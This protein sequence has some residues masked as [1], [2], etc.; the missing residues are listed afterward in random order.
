[1]KGGKNI[2]RSTGGIIAFFL[3]IGMSACAGNPQAIVDGK[4]GA[5]VTSGGKGTNDAAHRIR[6]NPVLDSTKPFREAL[7]LAFAESAVRLEGKESKIEGFLQNGE[8]RIAATAW[9]SPSP[10]GTIFVIHGF[11]STTRSFTIAIQRLSELGFD[12]VSIDLP[13][14]GKSDG[15]NDDIRNF[16]VYGDAVTAVLGSCEEIL[17]RP[18]LALG[19]SL[20]ALAV[21]DS[22]SRGSAVVLDAMMFITPLTRSIHWTSSYLGYRLARPF[23]SYT[24]DSN[25]K[26]F[27]LSWFGAMVEWNREAEG[28]PRIDVPAMVILGGADRVVDGPN[29]ERLFGDKISNVQFLRFRWLDHVEIMSSSPDPRLWNAIADFIK[30]FVIAK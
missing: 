26:R 11:G 9:L 29:A 5:M 24:R 15:S 21:Y 3:C 8:Y 10:L 12:V 19:H 14:H 17:P 13:G 30:P 7:Q 22:Q 20:G 23:I 16:R 25:G 4:H 28:F 2:S 1:M 27:P 18:F 6:M